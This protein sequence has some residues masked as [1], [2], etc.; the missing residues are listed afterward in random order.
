MSDTQFEIIYNSGTQLFTANY[1]YRDDKGTISRKPFETRR[2]DTFLKIMDFMKE[3]I[4]LESLVFNLDF[5][6]DE[7]MEE[8]EVKDEEEEEKKAAGKRKRRRR[9]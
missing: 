6:E 7:V 3:I 8:V 5:S 4:E 9:F 1:L 2:G